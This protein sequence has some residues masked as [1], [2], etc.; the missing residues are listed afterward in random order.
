MSF[1]RKKRSFFFSF[2]LKFTIISSVDQS[3]LIDKYH[4]NE[5]HKTF[6]SLIMKSGADLGGGGRADIF[7][8]RD[9]TSCRPKGP[10]FGTF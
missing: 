3:G 10:R 8:L 2:F 4:I 5:T 1:F 7:S 9:S 6:K